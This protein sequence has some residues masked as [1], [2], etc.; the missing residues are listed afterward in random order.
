MSMSM[1]KY[2]VYT[3]AQL[4]ERKIV[5]IAALHFNNSSLWQCAV[6]WNTSRCILWTRL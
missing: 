3:L 2:P 6:H 5:F 1:R 4:K